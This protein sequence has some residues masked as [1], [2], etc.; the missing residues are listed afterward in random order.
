MW[1]IL[2]NDSEKPESVSLNVFT[3]EMLPDGSE[4]NKTV[5][6][7]ISLQP[8]RVN[9]PPK[10]SQGVKVS[11]KGNPAITSELSFRILAEQLPSA[12]KPE[13]SSVRL[14]M[15][16]LAALYVVPTD[17]R[18]DIILESAIGA[19]KGELP[20]LS[21]S[22]RNNGTRHTHLFN[23]FI[24]IRQDPASPLTEIAG[25]AMSEIEG[26]NVLAMSS[27]SFFIPWPSAVPG[28]MYEGT[29]NAEIE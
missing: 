16:Y 11:Y 4:A 26:Q 1:L 15:R 5:G 28:L 7:I 21:I 3:R 25:E 10:S 8:S 13:G 2:A 19:K 29:F 6:G 17:S 22:I 27:R 20:G 18:P 23:T 14:L 12:E 24:R 9:L